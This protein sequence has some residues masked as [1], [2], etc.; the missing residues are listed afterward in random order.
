MEMAVPTVAAMDLGVMLPCLIQG[1]RINR[2]FP[3]VYWIVC[4]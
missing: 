1:R 3:I 2:V 4:S